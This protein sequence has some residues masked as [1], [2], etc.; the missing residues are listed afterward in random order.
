MVEKGLGLYRNISR[1]MKKQ[2]SQIEIT[3]YLYEVIPS[4]PASPAPP[5]LLT[6][7]A[8]A[9]PETE[10]PTLPLLSPQPTQHED[11]NKGLYDGPLFQLT[12]KQS[13]CCTI[14]KLIF[15]VCVHLCVITVQ[16]ELYET[17]SC[18]QQQCLSI[19]HA[20]QTSCARLVEIAYPYTSIRQVIFNK[21]LIMC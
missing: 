3:M 5:H 21:K 7:S 10:R 8:S 1:K 16:K 13:P 17:V 20:E 18:Q 14:N 12:N 11:E 9:A 2:K 15:C 19:H 6:C 4:V